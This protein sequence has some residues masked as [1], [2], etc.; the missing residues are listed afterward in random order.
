[1][2]LEQILCGKDKFE[3]IDDFMMTVMTSKNLP[4][5]FQW[6]GQLL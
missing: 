6:I 4:S 1:M 2:D 5:E 3:D